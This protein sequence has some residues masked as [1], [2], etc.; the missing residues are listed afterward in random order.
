MAA[1]PGKFARFRA[2]S[3]AIAGPFRWNVG[4]RRERLDLTNFESAVSATGVNVHTEGTTG[5]LDTT[6]Q[7]ETYMTDTAVNLFF[8]DASLSCDLLFRKTVALGYYGVSADVLSFSPSTEV[9]QVARA[10]V[11]LQA[12]GLVSPAAL[13]A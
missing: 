13:G 10:T 5:P 2:A 1:L 8:P 9:R 3:T 6:F 12:N 11:E 7:V 4:F